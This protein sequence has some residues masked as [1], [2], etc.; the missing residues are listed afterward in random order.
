MVASKR[1]NDDPALMS[2]GI[3]GLDD[4][5]RGG[6]VPRRLYLSKAP[7]VPA[8]PRRVCNFCSRVYAAGNPACS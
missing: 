5:L 4:V 3:E 2:S 1:K 6:L 7:P 8:K